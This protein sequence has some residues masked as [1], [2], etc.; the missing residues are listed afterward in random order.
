MK[1]FFGTKFF[2]MDYYI[3]ENIVLFYDTKKLDNLVSAFILHNY[4]DIKVKNSDIK[5]IL[6]SMPCKWIVNRPEEEEI[7][8]SMLYGNIEPCLSKD[9][10]VINNNLGVSLKSDKWNTNENTMKLK[11]IYKT[12][13][14]L[15]YS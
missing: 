2:D 5:N 9:E 3:C 8:I 15:S 1:F 13:I 14:Q 7:I 12:F 6:L 10:D 11:E 4:F